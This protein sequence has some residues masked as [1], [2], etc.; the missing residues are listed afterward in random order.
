MEKK[1][2]RLI[3]EED[4]KNPLTDEECARKLFLN[5]SEINKLRQ[6]LNIPDSRERRKPLLLEEIK[7]I[8]TE[9]AGIS[10]RNITVELNKRGFRISRY[11]V[12]KVLKDNNLIKA[13]FEN[14]E[15]PTYSRPARKDTG[16]DQVDPFSAMIGWDK[17]LRVKVE[18]AKAAIL[19]PPNGL[20]T[21][22]IG[23]TGV[24]KS[25]LAES[26]YR[27][28][29]EVKKASPQEYP[30]VTFNCADY[31]ENP[32]LLLSQLFGYCK[33]AFTGAETNKD[34]L[35]AKANG[36]IL[37]LDEVHRLPPEG[38]EML[39]HLIDKGKYRKLG[40]TGI[41]HEV[42]V[43]IIAATTEDIEKSL[44]STF[45]R[46]IPMVIELP[47][48]TM[49]PVEERLEII[50]MFFHQEA[51]RINKKIVVNYNVLRTLLVYNCIGNIGQ[52]RSDIQVACAR[53]FLNYMARDNEQDCIT[54]D[55]SVLPV[56]VAKGL[57]NV[58]WNRV[59]I[60]KYITNDLVFLPDE[61]EPEEIKESVYIFPNE[62]YK[63]IEEE[64][65][66][67]QKQG[68]PDEVINRIIGDNLEAKIIKIIRQIEKNKSKLITQ[69][70][71]MVVRP[72]IVDLVQEMIKIA[73]AELSDIDDTLFYCLATHLNAS[74]GRIKSGKFTANP[75][76]ERVKNDCPKEY[77]IAKEMAFLTNIHLGFELPEDEIGFIAMYLKALAK[78]GVN[79]KDS[80]GIVVVSHGHVAEGMAS[81]ANRLLGVDMVKAVEMSFEEKP[82]DAYERTL[83]AVMEVDHGKGVLLLVDMGSLA[84]FGNQITRET[85]INT[86]VVTRVDTLMVIDAIRKALLPDADLNVIADSLIKGK[87]INVSPY[88]D[89]LFDAAHEQVI[90]SL[91][92]TGEGTAQQ[93]ENIIKE[94]VYEINENIKI[95]TMGL[96]NE[97]G[98][99]EQ[100]DNIKENANIL[101]IV[102]TVDPGYPEIPFLPAVEFLKEDGC[103]K[104]LQIVRVRYNDSRPVYQDNF[105]SVFDKDLIIINKE[106]QDKD[107]ALHLLADAL[108]R[109]GYVTQN[110]I[111]GVLE[112]EKIGPTAI[113]TSLAI[114]HGYSEDIIK[115]A[116]G[117]MTLQ[118][119]VE[120]CEGRKI[121]LIFMLAL[122][123]KSRHEFQRIY[124][125]I[126]NREIADKIKTA[127]NVSMIMHI[128][129]SA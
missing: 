115:P 14:T 82:E 83:E 51:A 114:P 111:K 2:L 88:E 76:L 11:S 79:P 4:K 91:C 25:M 126:K 61:G 66:N 71:K 65:Q 101:A 6:S 37:F 103:R 119:P 24:G 63:N 13:E 16:K 116:I 5:R 57:L 105:N 23:A 12:S 117:V 75:H 84:S 32:Q 38:Q 44:L 98:I 54:I 121:S 80:I 67:L 123:E 97:K 127:E 120:W 102:G 45:R 7:R 94:K 89:V 40:E 36:G 99:I 77:K 50:K 42:K 33:G 41:V 58:K 109:K 113:G 87:N 29:L 92:L 27:F 68:L 64:Y 74:V 73:K 72:E 52:L 8:L 96:I 55:F 110:Y 18:Q 17:G 93:I 28:A 20:H 107:E 22:I 100:I 106:V 56:H 31:A 3:A 69:D 46:R 90:I 9:H 59:E 104:L 85:G 129:E 34:G 39:F 78:R 95:I 30:F 125:V 128:L 47:P 53:G 43:M 60:E 108:F 26:M 49:R 35:V 70:L 62:I 48:L 112:R 10:E 19:Y 122:N 124:R 1:L 86:R 118:K 21:L 15:Q 81:V